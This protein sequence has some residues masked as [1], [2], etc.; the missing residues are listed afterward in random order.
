MFREERSVWLKH[1]NQNVIEDVV[2]AIGKS[3]IKL[4]F[5]PKFNKKQLEIIV[6]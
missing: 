2:R 3:Q 5:N 1:K 6:Q 4:V